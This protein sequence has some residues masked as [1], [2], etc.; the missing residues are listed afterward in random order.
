MRKIL[1]RGQTRK[2]GEKVRVGDGKP[3]EGNW[4]YGGILQGSGDFSI[5]Y[6]GSEAVDFEKFMV[7]SDTIGQFTGMHDRNG[8]PIFEGDIVEFV[9]PSFRMVGNVVYIE[10]RYMINNIYDEEQDWENWKELEVIGNIYDNPELL[11]EN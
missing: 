8:K 4:V 10:G 2:K 5:I 1:F 6:S 3:V 11:E 7:Y 9:C